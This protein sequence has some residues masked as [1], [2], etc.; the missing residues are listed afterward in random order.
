MYIS[1]SAYLEK[2][3]VRSVV[4]LIIYSCVG[5]IIRR[6][7]L[8]QSTHQSVLNNNIENIAKITVIGTTANYEDL[9]RHEAIN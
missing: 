4:R 9:F 3:E 5:F 8:L 2:N 6:L 7:L 1:I